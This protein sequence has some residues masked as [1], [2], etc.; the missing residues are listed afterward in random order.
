MTSASQIFGKRPLTMCMSITPFTPA[1]EVDEPVLRAHLRRLASCGLGVYLGSPGSGEGHALT[2]DEHARLYE[3]GV[4]ECSGR[5]PVLANPREAREPGPMIELARMA[6]SAGVDAVQVYQI[7]GGHG[8]HPTTDELHLYFR[9][10][11]SEIDHPVVLGC[12][13]VAGYL[14][15]PSMLAAL[16][17]EFAHIVALNIVDTTTTYLAACRTALP[18]EVWIFAGQTTAV[19]GFALGASGVLSAAANVI[20]RT[21]AALSDAYASGDRAALTEAALRIQRFYT[22][23]VEGF[24]GAR[25]EKLLLRA[26]GQPGGG[27]IRRPYVFPDDDALAAATD[28]LRRLGVDEWEGVSLRP[29]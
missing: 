17:A 2:L 26:T 15:D 11:I 13:P 23:F 29:S 19:Q 1:G 18:D 7:D 12:N 5:T 14:A 25:W 24:A 4:S 28:V 9:E 6:A 27:G 8:Y 16:C 3:I 10:V 21:C 22:A 20:P